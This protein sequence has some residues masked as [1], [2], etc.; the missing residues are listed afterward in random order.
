MGEAVYETVCPV[1]EGTGKLETIKKY[2]QSRAQEIKAPTPCEACDG[3]GK[4]MILKI[5]RKKGK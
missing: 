3:T 4:I 2:K 5:F 1:C